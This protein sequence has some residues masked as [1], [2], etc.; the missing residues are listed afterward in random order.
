MA[1]SN[2][3]SRS[4][5]VNV[6]LE[7][8]RCVVSNPQATHRKRRTQIESRATHGLTPVAARGSALISRPRLLVVVFSVSHAYSPRRAPPAR[9]PAVIARV[10]A[11]HRPVRLAV[12]GAVR[13]VTCDWAA[14]R[15]RH[16]FGAPT[17]PRNSHHCSGGCTMLCHS[18]RHSFPLDHAHFVSCALWQTVRES[19]HS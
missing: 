8:G 16:V 11:P 13:P 10:S 14:C 7:S 2:C 6:H 3:S 5:G 4:S 1:P 18:T 12:T 9:R 17:A 19:K 15:A